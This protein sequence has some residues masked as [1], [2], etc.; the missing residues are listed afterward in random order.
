MNEERIPHLKA[1]FQPDPRGYYP[2]V[3]TVNEVGWDQLTHL[4]MLA[5]EENLPDGDLPELVFQHLKFNV[6]CKQQ[7]LPSPFFV[8]ARVIFHPSSPEILH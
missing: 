4:V 5:Q 3:T 2:E 1:H 6:P 8:T 7:I